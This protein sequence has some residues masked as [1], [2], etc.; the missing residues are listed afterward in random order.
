MTRICMQP[1]RRLLSG[2]LLLCC[3]LSAY[4]LS[5]PAG[6]EGGQIRCSD[7]LKPA[8]ARIALLFWGLSR[9]LNRTLPFIEMHVL[10]VLEKHDI[11]VDVFWHTVVSDS[12]FSHRSGEF[13]IKLEK[14][15]VA[16]MRPCKFSIVDEE[17]VSVQEFQLYCEAKG[18]TE[19]DFSRNILKE[20]KSGS[21]FNLW[22]HRFGIDRHL[23]C[24][25]YTQRLGFQIL[26]DHMHM[27]NFTYDAVL[28][29]RPDMAPLTDIDLPMNLNLIRHNKNKLWIPDYQH[30]GGL[31]DRVAYGSVEVMKRYLVNRGLAYRDHRKVWTK[32]SEMFLLQY[33]NNS[34]IELE[35]SSFR[36]IRVRSD[37]SVPNHDLSVKLMAIVDSNYLKTCFHSSNFINIDPVSCQLTPVNGTLYPG[38]YL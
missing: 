16:A 26:V 38:V 4:C 11:A 7:P 15:D 32:N 19:K 35:R 2:A 21:M 10:D 3:L 34:G 31:N 17:T 1:S 28:A 30:W 36:S 13:N 20:D 9:S 33:F 37:G 5:S 25:Y 8:A 18:W 14:L 23:L 27:H 12:I 6:G 22:G 29:L 24:A